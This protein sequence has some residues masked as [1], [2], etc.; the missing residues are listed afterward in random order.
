[1][2]LTRRD[3]CSQVRVCGYLVDVYCLGVK[4]VIGPR[5]MHDGD[6]PGFARSFVSAYQAPPL[7]VPIELARD[8]VYGAAVGYARNLGFTPTPGFKAAAEHLGPATGP[9]VIGFGR[10]GKPFFVQ[11]PRDNPTAVLRTLERS[12]GQ[13]N[14]DFLVTA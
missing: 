3:R 11:G 6:L 1:M 4:N 5:V 14:F 9:C 8:I 2:L 7:S 13:G 10:H 12:V